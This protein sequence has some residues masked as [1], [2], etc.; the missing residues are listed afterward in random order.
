MESEVLPDEV[1]PTITMMGGFVAIW[2]SVARLGKIAKYRTIVDMEYGVDVASMRLDDLDKKIVAAVR[3]RTLAGL[4]TRVVD[5]GCGKGGLCVALLAAGAEV[6]GI[7]IGAYET[8]IRESLMSADVDATRFSYY[9][10]DLRHGDIPACDM[11]V[12]QRVLHYVPYTDAQAWLKQC[13]TQAT[14][15]FVSMTGVATAIGQHY[16]AAQLPV[17]ERWGRLDEV[18]Q[19]LFSITAPLCLYT[20]TECL[21]LLRDAGWEVAWSR[22]SDFGNIKVV[23]G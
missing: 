3:E 17:H 21:Q 9:Q 6:I 1:G 8:T 20:E 4:S 13:R 14:Q 23:C 7:D 5:V 18:G 15:L 22:V 16:A 12:L 11:L 19:Q 10:Q 2:S